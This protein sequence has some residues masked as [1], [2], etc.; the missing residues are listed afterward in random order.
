VR[1]APNRSYAGAGMTMWVARPEFN[2]ALSKVRADIAKNS[3]GIKQ[4]NTRVAAE[5]AVNARQN[6]AIVKQNKALTAQSKTIAVVRREVKKAKENALLMAILSRPKTLPP[7]A[8][9]ATLNVTNND[10]TTQEIQVPQGTR[11]AY[12]PEKSNSLLLALALTG[13]F[14]GD[15][16]GGGSDSLLPIL[17]LAGG[18]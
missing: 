18:L 14:G 1:T 6:Q 2:Q 12:E 5:A 15:G 3:A 17:L 10:G 8:A 13:G 4:V 7:T 11:I 16:N 9:A